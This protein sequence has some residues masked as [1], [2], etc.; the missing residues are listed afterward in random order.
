[1]TRKIVE[2]LLRKAK[3]QGFLTQEE[4]LEGFPDAE[5]RIDELDTLYAALLSEGIDVFES[6]TPDEESEGRQSQ[7]SLDQEI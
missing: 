4:I 1:M 3:E 2:E 6:V 5:K 7:E